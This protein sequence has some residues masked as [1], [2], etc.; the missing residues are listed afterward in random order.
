[1]L[2][3]DL[4]KKLTQA[5]KKRGGISLKLVSPG[6]S[7]IPDRLILLPEGKHAFIE[8]KAPG[9]KPRPLQERWQVRLN[10]LG[11]Q[12]YVLD[13]PNHIESILDEIHTA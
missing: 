13:N 3:K 9:K 2:E 11:H 4:E 10:N 5:T 8:V 6:N 1:M 7:G 12:A